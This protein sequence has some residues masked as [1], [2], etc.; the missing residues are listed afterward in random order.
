MNFTVRKIEKKDD[1]TVE[2]I[3]RACLIE[4]GGNR[5]GLAWADP[6][7]CRFST[8]YNRDGWA[9]WVAELDSG[10]VVACSGIGDLGDG[11]CELQKMYCLAPY[12]GKGIGRALMDKCLD[13]A[14]KRYDKCY[15]E[16]LA[17]MEKANRFYQ[18]YGFV[19]LSEPYIKTEHYACDRWYLLDLKRQ[20][21]E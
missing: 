13:F 11:V 16:T 5:Q 21:S 7:L 18:N 1:K 4:F 20:K 10:E 12:R 3:I 14:K 2:Y 9:Y 15:I 17:N 19:S 8:L 6:D